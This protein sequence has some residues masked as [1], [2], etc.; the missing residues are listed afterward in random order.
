M[1]K[2]LP[3]SFTGANFETAKKN[4]WRNQREGLYSATHF[5]PIMYQGKKMYQPCNENDPLGLKIK[6]G[7]IIHDD[8]APISLPIS[9]QDIWTALKEV[10]VQSTLKA[11]QNELN[12]I[13]D[14]ISGC[15]AHF[16]Q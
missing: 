4:L 12:R 3:T 10:P 7:K 1:A 13:M 5:R 15:R 2:G 9:K 6:W 11:R 14:E 8:I 16:K